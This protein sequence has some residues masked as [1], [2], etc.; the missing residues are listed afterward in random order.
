MSSPSAADLGASTCG[1][2]WS[3]PGYLPP[4]SLVLGSSRLLARLLA[5]LASRFPPCAQLP[6]GQPSCMKCGR[7]LLGSVP[8]FRAFRGHLRFLGGSGHSTDPCFPQLLP[9]HRRVQAPGCH[10]QPVPDP[11]CGTDANLPGAGGGGHCLRQEAGRVSVGPWV[12]AGSACFPP[13]ASS[14][15]F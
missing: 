6:P 9:S 15:V 3:P 2:R 12:L 14:P 13:E 1:R 8:V 10:H 11:G 7:T 5:G 4:C